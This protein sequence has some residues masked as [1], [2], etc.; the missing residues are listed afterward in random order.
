MKKLKISIIGSCVT[1][2]LFNSKFISNYKDTYECVS[3]AWQTSMISFMSDKTYVN[4]NQR[5]FTGEVSKLQK[6]TTA[7]DIDKLY[8]D[9]LMEKQPDYIIFDLYT[10]VKYG[11]VKTEDG[12][13]TNNPNGFRKT[14]YFK[15]GHYKQKLN[16]FRD[17][18]YLD[19][20]HENFARFYEW[21]KKSIP[22]C[23]IVITKFSEAFSYMTKEGYPVN[24]SPKICGTVARDNKLYDKL[25]KTLAEKY[26]LDFIE[27]QSKTY[28]G[29]YDHLWGNK[30]W[31]FT[32]QYYDDLYKGFNEVVLRH[33][34][35][36][37]DVNMEDATQQ[38]TNTSSLFTQMMRK[39]IMK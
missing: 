12:Y 30:P 13:L 37:V 32:Q 18:E 2:G 21:V 36:S 34:L 3:T 5:E 20:F 29:D 10:D 26:D 31:H 24:Y 38:S 17:D 4:D 19:L 7:R 16:I 6:K 8:R 39:I 15:E 11:I 23:R 22:N 25:Y 9:E 27:M 1:R 28:F 33:Q 14:V 35:G